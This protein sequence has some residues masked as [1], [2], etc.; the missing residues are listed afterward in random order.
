MVHNTIAFAKETNSPSPFMPWS[1]DAFFEG[2]LPKNGRKSATAFIAKNDQHEILFPPTPDLT[3][4]F[5]SKS[6]SP[7]TSWL[8]HLQLPAKDVHGDFQI[9]IFSRK[10]P[11][12]EF[13]VKQ[14]VRWLDH[15]PC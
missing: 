1:Y 6:F 7:M 9:W 13:R 5:V 8:R 4:G 3:P 15:I 14:I 11:K 2:Y 12:T 10:N